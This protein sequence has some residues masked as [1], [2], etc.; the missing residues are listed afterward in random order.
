MLSIPATGQDGSF[1]D[2]TD[3]L[4]EVKQGIEDIYHFDFDSSDYVLHRL[5][6][7]YPGHPVTPFFE[8]MIY[9]WKYQP[10]VPEQEG[11]REF[12]T[13]MQQSWEL[14]EQRLKIDPDDI[15]GVFFNLMARAF[16]VMFYADNGHP[17]GAIPHILTVYHEIIKGYDLKASLIEFYFPVGLYQYYREAWPEAYPVYRPVT[18]FFKKGSKREGLELLH[19]AAENTFFMKVEAGMFLSLIYLNFEYNTDSAVSVCGKLYH[20]YPE[21]PFIAGR[22]AEILMI[23]KQY[24][25]ARPL[26]DILS[27][28]NDFAGMRATVYKGIYEEKVNKDFTRAASYYHSGLKMAEAF[29]A[30]ANYTRAYAYI[31]LSRHYKREG[32]EKLSRH[33]YRKARESTGFDFIFE[34]D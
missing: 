28:M 31:G 21:N 26:F 10:L 33:Y 7:A 29:G 34:D 9:Y 8:G 27:G 23:D 11:S 17:R 19:Y 20:D 30:Y 3:M 14:A 25:T 15:E 12:E 16:V 24:E 32:D 6:L 5:K 1:L 13:S 18:M 22:Y 4:D 2:D